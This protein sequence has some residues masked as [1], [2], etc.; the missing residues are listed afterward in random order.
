MFLGRRPAEHFDRDL[1]GFYTSLLEA[2][3][4][5]IFHDGHWVLCDRTGWPDNA[6]FQNLVAWGWV[7]HEERYLI[8]V[9]LSDCPSH[10][11]IQ[12]PWGDAG[13]GTW[14]LMDSLSGAYYERDGNQLSSRVYTSSSAPGITTFSIAYG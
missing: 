7:L 4:R 6:T 3:N 12:V 5:P 11:R 9:N 10:A 8:V 13:G 14:Q 1:Y 2:V